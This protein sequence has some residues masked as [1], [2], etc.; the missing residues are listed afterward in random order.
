MAYLFWKDDAG[1]WNEGLNCIACNKL[2][3][4]EDGGHKW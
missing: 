4:E 2:K 1:Q 3:L